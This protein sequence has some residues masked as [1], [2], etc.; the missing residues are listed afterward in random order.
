AGERVAEV[1]NVGTPVV[2]AALDPAVDVLAVEL[3]SFQLRFTRTTSLEAAAV[4]NVAPDH[5]DWH[6][7]LER[8]AADKGRIFTHAQRA[9]VY[10]VAD[11]VTRGLV[12]DADVVEGC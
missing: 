11:P 3:S 1:G 6:G 10:N 4:L 12:E 9:C 8:Y 2:E 7:S 5:L